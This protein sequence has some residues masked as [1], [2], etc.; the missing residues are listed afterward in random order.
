MT[1]AK[2]FVRRPE[3]HAVHLRGFA[4]GKGRDSDVELSDLSYEGCQIRSDDKFKQ[5]E[6]VELRIIKRGAIDAEVRWSA[7]GRAGVCFVGK[8]DG[9]VA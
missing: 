5:G 8:A 9:C 6:L 2:T 7:N 4:L 1:T 3:R